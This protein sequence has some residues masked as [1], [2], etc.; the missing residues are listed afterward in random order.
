MVHLNQQKESWI[1]DELMHMIIEKD[2]LILQAKILNTEM[3]WN[4]AKQAKNR[5]KKFIQRAKQTYISDTLETN[6]NNPKIFWRKINNILPNKKDKTTSKILL[7]NQQTQQIIDDKNISNYINDYF[8]TIG[9]KLAQNY[10]TDYSFHGPI[11]RKV[12]NF[13]QV[14]QEQVL[15]QITKIN[16]AKPSSIELLSTKLLKDIFLH[17]NNYLTILFYKCLQLNIF[18][19]KWKEATV[20]PLKKEGFTNNVSGLRP[21]SVLP[22]PGKIF[23]KLIHNQLYTYINNGQLI[24]EFQGGFRPNYSTNSTI[25]Q[26]TDYIYTNINQHKLTHSIF[27]D[28]SKAFDTI[29]YN[30]L[31]KKLEHFYL[32]DSAIDLIKNY[33]TNRKQK[34]QTNDNTSDTKLLTCGLPQGSVLGPLLFLLYINDLHLY[35]YDVHIS[36]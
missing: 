30:I 19:D 27:I 35:L 5:T 8:S 23:E 13:E 15:E 3:A 1:N 10:R 14:T 33:L 20:T 2:R 26:F 25:A 17:T 36:Q 21:I 18:P 28:F 9:P 24:S 4:I 29:N 12:F 11:G 32:K 34:V 7:K 6:K 16:I 31:F 22:L